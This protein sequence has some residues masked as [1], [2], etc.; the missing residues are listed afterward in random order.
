MKKKVITSAI[1]T[2]A[3][4]FSLLL[5]A[6]YALFTSESRNS[7]DITSGKVSVEAVVDKASIQTKELNKSYENGATNTF[8]GAVVFQANEIIL[9]ELVPGD[10]VKFTVDITNNSNVIVKYRVKISSATPTDVEPE[11]S[12]LLF[13]VLKFNVGGSDFNNVIM[14]KSAWTNLAVGSNPDSIDFEIELPETAGNEYQDLSTKIVLVVE[15]VQGNAPVT[16]GEEVIRLDGSAKLTDNGITLDIPAGA[17]EDGKIP[18]ISVSHEAEPNF[19]V[20]V[21]EEVVIKV[22]KIELPQLKSGNNKAITVKIPVDKLMEDAVVYYNNGTTLEAMHTEAS[23][24][25]GHYYVVFTTTHFS[26]YVLVERSYDALIINNDGKRTFAYG[27][28]NYI[29]SA[30]RYGD[31][32]QIAAQ[33]YDESI[34]GVVPIEIAKS[35]KILGADGTRFAASLTK[36]GVTTFYANFLEALAASNVG[37]GDSHVIMWSNV[38]LSEGIILG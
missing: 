29:M 18:V 13:S 25:N 26:E 4:A 28:L 5:G 6:T 33:T 12:Q 34:I 24:E 8:A 38:D 35:I 37:D 17:V 20:L 7:I 21:P 9:E 1:L 14:Y 11:D 10:G 22:L 3:L 2:I 31:T 19:E 32:I 16:A 30:A 15:A 23:E 27:N 36:N